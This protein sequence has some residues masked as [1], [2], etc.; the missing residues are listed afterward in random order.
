M[1]EWMYLDVSGGDWGADAFGE[2][3]RIAVSGEPVA[4]RF[5][6][7]SVA[8]RTFIICFIRHPKR[9]WCGC[10]SLNCTLITSGS[11]RSGALTLH[12]WPFAAGVCILSCAAA[13]WSTNV[14]Q[15]SSAAKEHCHSVPSAV[16]AA[17]LHL[18][19]RVCGA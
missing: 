8:V 10:A 17:E 4:V 9:C 6:R 14:F 7:R 1:T 19:E 16:L 11:T 2:R 5:L 18:I 15:F 12:A 13:G 3:M